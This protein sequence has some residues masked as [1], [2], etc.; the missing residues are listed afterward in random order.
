MAHKQYVLCITGQKRATVLYSSPP[1]SLPAL[2]DLHMC[3]SKGPLHPLFESDATVMHGIL[4]TGT[5][6]VNSRLTY[7][8]YRGTETSISLRDGQVS[9]EKPY[10][11]RCTAAQILPSFQI[12]FYEGVKAFLHESICFSRVLNLYIFLA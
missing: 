2:P 3:H 10:R 11:L 12:H 7:S 6:L 1:L 8:S 9:R 5:S 4:C